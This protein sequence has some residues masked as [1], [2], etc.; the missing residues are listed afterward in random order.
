MDKK[1]LRVI[2]QDLQEILHLAE[3]IL[4][5]LKTNKIRQAQKELQKI[6][7][8]NLDEIYRLHEEV[9]DDGATK[10]LLYECGIVLNDVKKALQEL[11][12]ANLPDNVMLVVDKIIQMERHGI[13]IIEEENR[14]YDLIY[15]WWYNNVYCSFLYHGTTTIFEK[16]L[17]KNGMDPA[18]RPYEAKI[19]EFLRFISKYPSF[20]HSRLGYNISAFTLR[21]PELYWSLNYWYVENDFLRGRGQAGGEI[22]S[23]IDNS[24]SDLLT[25]ANQQMISLSSKEIS[26]LQEIMKWTTKLRTRAKPLLLKIRLSSPWLAEHIPNHFNFEPRIIG[27]FEQIK[28]SLINYFQVR[29]LQWNIDSVSKFLQE[30]TVALE[31][32]K[33]HNYQVIIK[34][35]IPSSEIVFEHP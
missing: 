7:S 9:N 23:G 28:I 32:R 3:S 21:K 4:R 6:I 17:R 29:S 26:Y 18:W 25:A 30:R 15:Y 12:S 19:R 24:A 1:K 16:V 10:Q 22:I 31:E 27:S 5:H 14:V 2:L 8:L 11:G 13:T 33:S 20:I 35:H 34:D